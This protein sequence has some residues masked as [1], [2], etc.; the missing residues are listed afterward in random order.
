MVKDYE[1]GRLFMVYHP[2]NDHVKNKVYRLNDDVLGVYYV[3][4][5]SQIL[6][7]SFELS[8]IQAL[9]KDLAS[10]PMAQYVEVV[11]KYEFQET[12][13]FDF[14][15][16]GYD[17][18]AVEYIATAGWFVQLLPLMFCW[19]LFLTAF[20]VFVSTAAKTSVTALTVTLTTTLAA[21]VMQPY[22]TGIPGFSAIWPFSYADPMAVLS[23][24]LQTTAL[25]GIVV[26]LGFSAALI[27]ASFVMFCRE[28]VTC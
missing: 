18:Q 4:D 2:H 23:G 3:V 26:L 15:N 21:S 12:I 28:D 13:L 6:I 19:L 5:D 24:E 20:A 7:S 8:G 16:S 9:E 25:C 17:V 1:G 10:S 11:S 22:L 27:T 14:I